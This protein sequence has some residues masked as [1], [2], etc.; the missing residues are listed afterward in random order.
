MDK[1]SS[2]VRSTAAIAGHPLHPVF[3][4]FPIAFLIGLLATDI[5]YTASRIPLW[6]EFSKW[7]ALSGVVMGGVAA[8]LGLIDFVTIN[9]VRQESAGWIHF[10]GNVAAMIIAV[11]NTVIHWSNP[12]GSIIPGGIVLSAVTVF[13]LAITGWY[14]GELAYRYGIG[15]LISPAKDKSGEMPHRRAA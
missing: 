11:I 9:R 15:V 14:G 3:I 6:A 1:Y 2:G 5:V 7:L 4:V 13:I 12:L 10:T 8:V